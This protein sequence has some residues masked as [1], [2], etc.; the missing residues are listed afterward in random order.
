[1]ALR[2]CD[3]QIGLV[4]KQDHLH[5]LGAC[6]SM[7]LIPRFCDQY[8]DS[9]IQRQSG[10]MFVVLQQ[11]EINA[12]SIG[13]TLSAGR[14]GWCFSQAT[15]T[16]AGRYFIARK[17]ENNNYFVRST[18][19]GDPESREGADDRKRS[20]GQMQLDWPSR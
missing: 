13:N 15:T 8:L 19:T 20:I 2:D 18:A 4:S 5:T 9:I 12:R 1:M 14:K 11:G 7:P 16:E 17:G 10:G 3:G 6:H